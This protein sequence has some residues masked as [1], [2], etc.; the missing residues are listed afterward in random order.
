LPGQNQLLEGSLA[1]V[2]EE[3]AQGV[4]IRYGERVV[5]VKAAPDGTGPRW[6]VT[7]ET[8]SFPADAVIVTTPVGALQAARIHFEPPLPTEVMAALA[9]IGP[10]RAAKVFVT[11]D[12]A[13]WAPERSFWLVAEEPVPLGLWIDVS[14]L[15]GRPMLCGFATSDQVARVETMS[16]DELCHLALE[17][18]QRAGVLPQ[19][20]PH[21]GLSSRSDRPPGRE[22][23]PPR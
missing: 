16:E 14:V 2:V 7:T 11:F 17:L 15:A 13:F 9:R 20:P 21:G 4:D 19:R 8:R 6:T 23:A 22:T 5:A 18:L 1:R 3:L 10:G 12:E